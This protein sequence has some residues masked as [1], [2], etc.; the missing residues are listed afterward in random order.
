M[1]LHIQPQD[2]EAVGKYLQLCSFDEDFTVMSHMLGSY[3][4]LPGNLV[5]LEV[6]VMPALGV[7][8]PL[9]SNKVQ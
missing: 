8:W 9:I 4:R 3:N 2:A 5:R 7:L 6:W 1:Q